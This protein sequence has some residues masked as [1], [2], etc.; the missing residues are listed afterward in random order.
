MN[1]PVKPEQLKLSSGTSSDAPSLK[2]ADDPVTKEVIGRASAILAQAANPD[3]FDWD[4]DDSVILREQRATAAY[5]NRHGELIIRQRAPW[6]DE[7]TFVYI[8]P[9][10]EIAFME[11]LAKR[12]REG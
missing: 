3:E 4:A 2:N 5:R 6:P 1:K 11:G 8:S 12:A 7:D 9:K 10:N